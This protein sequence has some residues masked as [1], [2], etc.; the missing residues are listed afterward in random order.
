MDILNAF[1]VNTHTI[2]AELTAEK[3]KTN[4]QYHENILLIWST[5][6]PLLQ[7]RTAL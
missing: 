5:T 2:L 1:V 7:E 6:E 4:K 3:K